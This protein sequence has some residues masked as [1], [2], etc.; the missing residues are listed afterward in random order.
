MDWTRRTAGEIMSAVGIASIALGIFVV[1]GRGPLLVA[2]AATL[3]WFNSVIETN[4]RIRVLGIVVLLVGAGM[5]LAG[6]TEGSTLASILTIWGWAMVALGTLAL[7]IFPGAY[8][9][10]ASAFLP[11]KEEESLPGWRLMGGLGTI[12]GLMLIYFG[13]LAL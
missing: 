13:V 6:A 1:C 11:A 2:P 12:V 7:M 3:R 5:I 10:F 9:E 4:S 8:R